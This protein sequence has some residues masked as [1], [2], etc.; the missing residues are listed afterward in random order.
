MDQRQATAHT[1]N[2]DDGNSWKIM[3]LHIYYKAD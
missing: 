3:Q 2:V 1:V